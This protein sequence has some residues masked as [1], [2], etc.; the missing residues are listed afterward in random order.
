MSRVEVGSAV[1]AP[2]EM[3]SGPATCVVFW[4]TGQPGATAAIARPSDLGEVGTEENAVDKVLVGRVLAK[5]S[6]QQEAQAQEVLPVPGGEEREGKALPWPSANC[7]VNRRSKGSKKSARMPRRRRMPYVPPTRN[8]RK[9]WR[10]P[11]W[12]TSSLKKTTEWMMTK[13]PKSRAKKRSTQ[14]RRRSPISFYNTER[15]PTRWRKPAMRLRSSSGRPGRRN[16]TRPIV[17]SWNADLT[18]C[19]GSRRRPRRRN[20]RCCRRSNSP[21]ATQQTAGD[22]RRTREEHHSSRRGT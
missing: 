16:P 22:D 17:V 8:S 21:G 7:S 14:R 6:E 20:T 10:Q 13:K 12:A 15:T 1:S 5:A 19:G 2:C 11:K 18:V 3:A 4:T 9:N